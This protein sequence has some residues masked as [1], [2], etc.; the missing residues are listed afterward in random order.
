MTR[1]IKFRV[2][3]YIESWNDCGLKLDV[4]LDLKEE[5]IDRLLKIYMYSVL[6][7]FLF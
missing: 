6:L 3:G 2:L 4:D 5:L 7:L 1:A